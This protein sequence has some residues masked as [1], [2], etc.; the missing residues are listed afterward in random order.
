VP[1]FSSLSFEILDITFS[2]QTSK[3][4]LFDLTYASI[5]TVVAT[6]RDD[7]NVHIE[8]LSTAGFTIRTSDFYTGTVSVHVIAG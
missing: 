4:V 7:I 1:L 5:P 8:N 6:P 3:T 2:N